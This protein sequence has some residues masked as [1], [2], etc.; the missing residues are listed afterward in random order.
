MQN[1]VPVKV[2]DVIEEKCI[3]IG[4][5]GDGIFKKDGFVILVPKTEFNRKYEI[6][7]TRVSN[8]FSFGEVI[9]EAI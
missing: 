7:I 4:K 3:A 5:K 8:N 1:K 6:K 2:G 9:Q